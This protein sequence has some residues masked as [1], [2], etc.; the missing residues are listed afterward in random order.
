MPNGNLQ[1]VSSDG[2][3]A[4]QR[5]VT[6]KGPLNIH[7]LF[8]FHDAVRADPPPTLIL[9]FS[10]VPYMDSA[11]LGAL[12]ATHMAAQKGS[13]RLGLV[14]INKQVQAVMDMTHVTPLFHSFATVSEAEA[15]LG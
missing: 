15:A 13:R 9:D 6:L 3:S 4:G 12:V 10:A 8:V 5:I 1:I 7:T 2:S 14:G 11:G